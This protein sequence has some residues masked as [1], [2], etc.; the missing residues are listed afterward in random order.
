MASARQATLIQQRASAV[1]AVLKRQGYGGS[2][3]PRQYE[4]LFRTGNVRI[5]AVVDWL[6]RNLKH[7][8]ALTSHL[9]PAEMTLY[10]KLLD[11]GRLI[12]D[13]RALA[14]A[15]LEVDGAVS[16]TRAHGGGATDA[17]GSGS[18]GAGGDATATTQSVGQSDLFLGGR[19]LATITRDNHA[20]AQEV[21]VLQARL[22]QVS[23][24]R[25]T[26]LAMNQR[27][28]REAVADGRRAEEARRST[29]AK[30]V[31]S[32]AGTEGDAAS[33]DKEL[34][35]LGHTVAEVA[36]TLGAPGG[37][38]G[39]KPGPLMSQADF[40][41]Y[42]VA[43]R[44]YVRAI[45]GF[46]DKQFHSGL[47][48][49]AQRMCGGKPEWDGDAA[50]FSHMLQGLSDAERDARK[51]QLRRL[52]VSSRSVVCVCLCGVYV[53]CVC[54]CGVCVCV[55]C[56]CVSVCVCVCVIGWMVRSLRHAFFCDWLCITLGVPH[57]MRTA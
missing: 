31:A 1:A 41:D 19:T 34:S 4:P 28:S 56:V 25:D 16:H 44:D 3:N 47:Q 13:R 52:R 20:L 17:A 57:R 42:D 45:N 50:E 30:L 2:T 29:L 24:Q 11:G 54:M 49:V 36:A 18:G 8:H 27:A 33:L 5:E 35:R 43:E 51:R 40:S 32:V 23:Q 46:M 15:E 21:A 55:V 9:S 14:A 26:F 53:W 10:H 22:Q 38:D 6:V 39:A 7:D 37:G 48:H 12:T